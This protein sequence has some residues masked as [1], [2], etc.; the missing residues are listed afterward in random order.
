M[1]Y[2]EGFYLKLKLIS[3][4]WTTIIILIHSE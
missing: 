4:K 3:H 2:V 1:D